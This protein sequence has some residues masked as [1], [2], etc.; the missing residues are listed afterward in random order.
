MRR[1]INVTVRHGELD[2][3]GRPGSGG[4]GQGGH[5][6]R[7]RI[8][9]AAL[10]GWAAAPDLHVYYPR[11]EHRACAHCRRRPVSSAPWRPFNRLMDLLCA[12]CRIQT[13]RYAERI[14]ERTGRRVAEHLDQVLATL[15]LE[16]H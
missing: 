14:A 6:P 15:R 16:V 2:H 8:D 3:W 11:L 4:D 1:I 5:A 10:R 9:Y 12:E 7:V 13:Y